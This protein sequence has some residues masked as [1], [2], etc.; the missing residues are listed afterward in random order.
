MDH[1]LATR[2]SD[3]LKSYPPFNLMEPELLL[4]VSN[5]VT[6]QYYEPDQ[7][8]FKEDDQPG[9]QIFIVREGAIQLLKTT[10]ETPLLF[11]VCDEGDVFGIRPILA[12][13]P[14]ALSAQA[15][16]ESLVYAI[17]IEGFE[18]QLLE[19]PRISLYLAANFASRL[20]DKYGA[21]NNR[22]LFLE[23]QQ[24]IDS[25]FKLVE[26]QSIEGSKTP[27][28][29]P[30]GKQIQ[31]AA[32][33]M[34][35]HRVGSIIIINEANHP[36]GIITDKDLRNH[37]AT[38]QV[39]LD[40]S[41]GEIMSSPVITVL[42]GVTIADV[43]IQMVRNRIHH[44]CITEDGTDQSAVIGVISEHDLL[45]IQG[46]NPA[47]LVREIQKS[48]SGQELGAIRDKAETLLEKYIFQEVAISFI[49]TVMTEI[50]DAINHKA[51]ELGIK[52]MEEA[53]KKL[54]D[55]PFCW[56]ALGSLGRGEQL[57]RTDQDNALVYEDVPKAEEESV[58]AYF[59][60]LAGLVT[61]TLD[62]AGFEYCPAEMMASNPKWCLSLREW[63]KQFSHWIEEP[64]ER[65]IMYCTIFFDYR[66]IY[67]EK[68]LSAALS[69]HIFEAI[70]SRS[71]FLN[72]LAKNALQNPPPLSFFRNFVV[73]KG[74]E[75]KNEFDI[76]KRAM[77]PLADAAR[78]L[79]LEKRTPTINNTFRRFDR[80]AELEPQNKELFEAAS[81]AYEILMRYR[82]LQGL[83][84]K[85]S[86]RFFKPDE[87]SK[88]ERMN[89][90]NCFQPIVEIQKLLKTRFQLGYMM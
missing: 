59:L 49:S 74:G 6:V 5:R 78:T 79:I 63:K 32:N 75:H 24:L 73:E 35:T 1:T 76:K 30:A 51:I 16:E 22:P 19:H 80:L 46:N 66:P 10:E 21:S 86:G 28:T 13:E 68:E 82:A 39:S 48:K 29:C 72:F 50:N 89:L 43:Q 52:E 90:R 65:A 57:L 44:L 26:I 27:V 36:K 58:K 25:K 3:F 60:E 31:E 85:D 47:I 45:V 70:E 9:K 42:P 64:N 38:G 77:M 20:R 67:G 18:D 71:I 41:V 14:Y 54:P 33:I 8:I 40:A 83:K 62:Q 37:V 53:G 4:Q 84:N 7:W 69:N 55:V 11:D 15:G 12:N 23:K 81:D 2:V 88:M 56:L 17:N 34:A 61:H 87:L